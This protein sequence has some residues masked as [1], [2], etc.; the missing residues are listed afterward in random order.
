ML[1]NRCILF[2]SFSCIAACLRGQ[3]VDL[4][5]Y[6]QCDSI[7]IDEMR[8]M[9]YTDNVQDTALYDILIN[10]PHN[11]FT[12]ITSAKGLHDADGIKLPPSVWT[13]SE[14]CNNFEHE[15]LIWLGVC[16]GTSDSTKITQ[17]MIKRYENNVLKNLDRNYNIGI[18]AEWCSDTIITMHNIMSCKGYILGEQPV[19]YIFKNGENVSFNNKNVIGGMPILPQ[20]YYDREHSLV[21][22]P[23]MVAWHNY[24]ND[25]KAAI[26]LFLLHHDINRYCSLY[27]HMKENKTFALLLYFDDKQKCHVDVLL[28]DNNI[29]EEDNALIHELKNAVDKLQENVLQSLWTYDNKVFPGRYL[30]AICD[31]VYGW[32]F[33]DY[34]Y[35]DSGILSDDFIK[36]K[37][38]N[39]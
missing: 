26:D 22:F 16:S 18:V 39:W 15:K 31:K 24:N 14:P 1:R 36:Y 37:N 7:S 6:K 25:V 38:A 32:R 30:M 19:C 17:S 21:R 8:G 23:N 10:F 29:D 9:F 12:Y 33:K 11:T 4:P 34:R 20:P 3:T 2:I 28:P 13:L 35:K 27:K 5:L